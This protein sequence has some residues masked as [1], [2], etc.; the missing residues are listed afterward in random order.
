VP[1]GIAALVAET[2]PA[3]CAAFNVGG[4]KAFPGIRYSDDAANISL[5]FGTVPSPTPRQRAM[6]NRMM[7]VFLRFARTGDPRARKP[8]LFATAP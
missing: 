4:E 7:A 6:S 1:E 2:T 5:M 8:E 3:P